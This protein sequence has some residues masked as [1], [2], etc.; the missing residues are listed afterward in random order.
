[1]LY[2]QLAFN[3][4]NIGK[5]D[6]FFET[7]TKLIGGTA[8]ALNVVDYGF[9]IYEGR[10]SVLS[11]RSLLLAGDLY[12]AKLG[13]SSGQGFILNLGWESGKAAAKYRIHLT[14]KYSPGG[15][16]GLLSTDY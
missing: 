3:D 10:N 15:L 5:I 4:F 6:P 14:E 8:A 2:T 12:M 1:M 11:A 7:R 16:D 9:D 13:T